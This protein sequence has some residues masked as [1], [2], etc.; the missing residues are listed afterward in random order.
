MT[1]DPLHIAAT[2]PLILSG[3]LVLRGDARGLRTERREVLVQ[4]GRIAALLPESEAGPPEAEHICAADR[5]V[6][7]GLVNAHTHGHGALG[8]GAVGDRVL[9]EMFLGAAGAINGGRGLDDKRLTAELSA[10]ELIRRGCTACYDLFVELPG[11]T[12]EG[13]DAVAEAYAGAGLRA[14]VAPMMADRTLWQALPGLAE[15]LPGPLR[16]Q[17][18]ALATPPFADSLAACRA[19]LR[20]WRQDRALVRPALAP[21]IPLHCSDAFLTGC[22]DLAAEHDVGLQTHLGET[23]TQAVIG[24]ARYGRTLTAHLQALGLLGPRFS[25]AHGIWLDADDIARLAEAGIAGVAHNP[26][27]NLRIG[28]GVAPARRL[29]EAG[30]NLGIGTDASNTS[31][32]QNMF[33]ATRLGAFLSRLADADPEGWLSAEEAFAAAT[34]GS[35]RILGFD[36]VG[37][38]EPG[39]AADLVLLDLAAPH[40]VPLRD[41]LRQLV[42]AENAA[43]VTDVMIAGR[44]VMRDRVLLTLDEARLRRAAEAAAARLDALNANAREFAEAVSRHIACFCLGQQ[45]LPPA[46]PRRLAQ[47]GPSGR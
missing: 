34:T 23:K 40:Y 1:A 9:L 6:I 11:P 15:A 18:V 22:R 30:V 2:R 42:F 31:D 16:A 4:D 45:A 25:A 21:T 10:A 24:L 32:G 46:L 5:L 38:I 14:V 37:R 3:G 44:M 20:G 17:A 41:P 35:A 28:S 26:M 7:P 12:P 19:M 33:E 29:L 47:N 36:R 8:R 27:S 39:W 43:S 13:L